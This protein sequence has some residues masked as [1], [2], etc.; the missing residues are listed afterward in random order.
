MLSL[1]LASFISCTNIIAHVL[2]LHLII[3]G[4]NRFKK[5]ASTVDNIFKAISTVTYF[6]VHCLYD[7]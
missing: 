5:Q 3:I 6:T 1:E 7:F 4:Q 2:V